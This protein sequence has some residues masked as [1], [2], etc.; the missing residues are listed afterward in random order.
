MSRLSSSLRRLFL[1]LPILSCLAVAP[2]GADY[3]DDYRF[4][5]AGSVDVGSQPV[6]FPDVMF[7]EVM[8][9]DLWLREALA[10]AGLEWREY[11]FFKGKDILPYLDGERLEAAFFGDMPTIS[12]AARH[13]VVVVGLI[14]QTFSTV[15]ARRYMRLQDLRGK[16]IGFAHGSTAHY[17]LLQGLKAGGLTE[18]DVQLVPMEVNQ[19][20]RALAEGEVEAFSAWEPAPTIALHRIEG[21]AVVYRGINTSY[22]VMTRR[23]LEHHPELAR[24]MGMALIRAVN[25]LAAGRGNLQRAAGWSL[26]A[27]YAFTGKLPELKVEQAVEITRKEVL[28]GAGPPLIPGAFLSHGGVLAQEFHFL[29][30]LGMLPPESTWEKVRERFDPAFLRQL[31]SGEEQHRLM[32]FRYAEE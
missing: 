15:V 20:P 12:A 13:D 3:P 27:G 22:F 21:A 26:A 30:Q 14:K 9:R 23:F 17:T 31:M 11:P 1:L 7:S 16:R 2:V 32:E 10:K 6:S 8:R 24:E 28:E 29:H 25:W 19:M 5:P 18:L 4:A